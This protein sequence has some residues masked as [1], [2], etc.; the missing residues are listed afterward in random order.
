MFDRE[1]GESSRATFNGFGAKHSE[2]GGGGV[3]SCLT[4]RAWRRE[5]RGSASIFR[6]IKP[7]QK[8]AVGGEGGGGGPPSS[9]PDIP[10]IFLLFL[11]FF[12][13]SLS[14]VLSSYF[15]FPN[16]LAA[17]GLRGGVDST[18]FAEVSR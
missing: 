6:E 14:L 15:F 18:R 17:P 5:I 4:I 16:S 11:L 13:L 3:Y 10:V 12:I 8:S 7:R 1:K 9:A 2:G